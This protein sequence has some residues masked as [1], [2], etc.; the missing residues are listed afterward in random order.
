MATISKKQ[1]PDHC[2]DSLMILSH[3]F[4]S[5]CSLAA[6]ISCTKRKFFVRIKPLHSLC[7]AKLNAK[8]EN[9]TTKVMLSY[10]KREKNVSFGARDFCRQRATR[11]ENVTQ[12]YQ[13]ADTM[14]GCLLS[15]DGVW[16]TKIAYYYPQNTL[17]FGFGHVCVWIFCYGHKFFCC[18]RA[19]RCENVTQYY[20]AADTMIGCLLLRDGIRVHKIGYCYP[21]NIL[22]FGFGFSVMGSRFLPPEPQWARIRTWE[23]PRF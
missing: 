10:L 5:C 8:L 12:Y 18:Q 17:N 22:T 9:S 2:V 21:K 20:Q 11:C 23:N 15:R 4:T 19:T 6:K 3:I 7:M 14:I 13:A 16:V 1:A